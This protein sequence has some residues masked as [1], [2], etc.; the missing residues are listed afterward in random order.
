MRI[1][2]LCGDRGIRLEKKNGGAAHF[3]SLVRA[4]SLNGHDLLVLTPSDADEEE[5]G[6][7]VSRIPTPR[8]LEDLH[9][10]VDQP[11]PRA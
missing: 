3:R 8:T 1:L 6:V 10:D 11:V 7:P 2:Y 9:A 5:L 4:L